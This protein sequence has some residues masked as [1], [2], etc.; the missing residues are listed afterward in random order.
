MMIV[1]QTDARIIEPIL[2]WS[3][4]SPA[5]NGLF[6]DGCWIS[7]PLNRTDWKL[8]ARLFPR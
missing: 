1:A 7:A 6:R 4:G 5:G 8:M 3:C 2:E